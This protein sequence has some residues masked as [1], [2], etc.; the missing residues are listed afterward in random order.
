MD[1]SLLDYLKT[2]GIH[3]VYG[4]RAATNCQKIITPYLL[5]V[6]KT[7]RAGELVSQIQLQKSQVQPGELALF[8]NILNRT[9]DLAQNWNLESRTSGNSQ[10][11]ESVI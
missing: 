5:I 3:L 6:M 7:S 2:I 10:Y 4:L 1:S 9:T 11:L 8:N